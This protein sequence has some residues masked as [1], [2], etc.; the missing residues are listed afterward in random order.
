MVRRDP[1]FTFVSKGGKP[2]RL[3]LEKNIT[4]FLDS[5]R[6]AKRSE[7]TIKA[8][9]QTLD[10][11]HKWYQSGNN[12][13]ITTDLLRHYIDYLTFSKEKWDDHPTNPTGAVGLAP[14]SV[15][16]TI[17]FLRIFFNYMVDERI[18]SYSPAAA[19][20][21]QKVEKDTFA[22]FTDEEVVKLL[23]AP[24]RRVY[25]GLR[26]YCMML[27][28]C[29]TGVR[30]SEL[31]GIRVCDIDFRLRHIAIMPETSKSGTLRIVPISPLTCKE[32]EKLIAFMNV[33]PTDYLW[34]TQFGERYLGNTFAKMLKIY[35]KRANIVGPRVSPHTFRH[36]FAVKF[37]RGGG[38]IM[39][40]VRIMGHIS[41]EM[42]QT[43][44]RYTG[45]VLS[46]QHDKASPVTQLLDK[47]NEKKRGK[48]KFK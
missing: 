23:A 21:Y 15:N 9:K 3:A 38:D 8:Y 48:Q 7:K 30:L 6:R 40:L 42:T 24:N 20:Q 14:K 44:V 31:T 22:V 28:L 39:A 18:I 26:D 46:E 32:L 12:V 33:E 4:Q 19:L 29:D 45:T 37:L 47:G 11:F 27:V 34:L 16:N 43:Y 36:Y 5:K 1:Q 25:T 35:A 13:A 17:K 41:L 2:V 10:Q